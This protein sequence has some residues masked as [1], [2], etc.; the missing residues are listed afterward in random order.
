MVARV[1]YEASGGFEPALEML[2]RRA[3]AR[4]LAMN[5]TR[6]EE[7]A[8]VDYLYVD[9]GSHN[10]F[11]RVKPAAYAGG[12]VDLGKYVDLVREAAESVLA[13]FEG[14]G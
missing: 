6:V 12:R 2:E 9:A 11:R 5:G 10:P 3:A 4:L 7:D 1:P 13:P 14:P 8:V